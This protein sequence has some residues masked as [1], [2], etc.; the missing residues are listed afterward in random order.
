MTKLLAILYRFTVSQPTFLTA[1][2]D[3]IECLGVS[4]RSAAD[5]TYSHP[6]LIYRAYH[7]DRI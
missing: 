6:S 5:F 3:S 1:V 4:P 7:R 2:P